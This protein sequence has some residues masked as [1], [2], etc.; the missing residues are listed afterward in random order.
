[1]SQLKVNTIRHTGASS[2]AITLAADGTAAIG[3]C[4]AKIT[5]QPTGTRNLIINGAMRVAQRGTSTTA[6]GY[7]TVDRF[8]TGTTGNDN[9]L[10]QEQ[11][12]LTSSDTG[13][14]EKGFRKALQLKNGNQT[15][16][17]QAGDNAYIAYAIEAQDL[18]NSG[19][20]Y[21]SASSYIT[22]SFWI[23]SSVAGNN[24][25]HL[26]NFDGT[27]QGYSFLSGNLSANTWTKVTH[28]IP[29][30]SNLTLD[31]N[32]SHG[33]WIQWSAYLGTSYTTSGHTVNQWAAYNSAS[34]QPDMAADTWWT[35]N[36]ATY[37]L[38]GVQLEVG[39]VA[40]DFEHRSYSDELLRCK[41]YFNM[42]ADGSL[43]TAKMISDAFWWS[44]NEIDFMYTFPVEMR[45][46]PTV[47]Q[48]MDTAYVQ[49]QGGGVSPTLDNDWTFQYNT[50][51]GTSM[52]CGKTGGGTAGN[53]AHLTVNNALF[54]LG[55]QSEL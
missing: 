38:T 11:I 8:Q 28:S 50:K 32:N 12:T 10:T 33:F 16:G 23:K 20:N 46:A 21:K 55:F 26:Y 45:D 31:N 43:G 19:W 2:D 7:G 15:S 24:W 9:A 48:V 27:T 36:L 35:T 3:E 17:T 30:N 6:N 53:S 47:Y 22:L 54:R 40:T 18:V 34:R 29:G 52:Y 44:N 37:A 51:K 14:W 1:M 5:N 41:R 42:M 13:P 25:V 4:T 39:D 49:V